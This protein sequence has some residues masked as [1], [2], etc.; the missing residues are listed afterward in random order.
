MINI[1]NF[2]PNLL[3][4]DKKSNQNTDIYYIGYIT[5]KNIGD[6]ESIHSVNPLY[7]IIGEV[8]GYI[9]EKNGNK[10]L[11]SASTDKNKDVLQKY[12]E[13]WDGIKNLTKKISDK[14]SEYGKDFMKIRFNSDDNLPLN[15][16]LKLHTL[17]IIARSVFQED[18]KYY[19]QMF[20][21]KCLY[22]L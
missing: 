8:D 5:M 7:F 2:N 17:T 1:K 13:L 19:P 21:G 12:T 22:E 20:L 4:V 11:V 14:P 3:K 15:K 9:E 10:Y 18:G 16:I 6:Y